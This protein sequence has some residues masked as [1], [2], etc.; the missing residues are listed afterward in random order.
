MVKTSRAERKDVARKKKVHLILEWL[1]L[2]HNGM[3]RGESTKSLVVK[4]ANTAKALIKESPQEKSL[5]EDA[6]SEFIQKLFP[7]NFQPS[8]DGSGAPL[9]KQTQG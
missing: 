9:P 4:V 2:F 3:K 5:I 7:E 6:F 1:T 8:S